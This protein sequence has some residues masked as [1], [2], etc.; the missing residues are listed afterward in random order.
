MSVRQCATSKGLVASSCLKMV[1]KSGETVDL[2]PVNVRRLYQSGFSP[3]SLSADLDGE[4][5]LIPP[6]ERIERIDTTADPRWVLIVEKDV[7]HQF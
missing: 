5:T 2:S 6:A 1:L 4:A 3:S 7:S